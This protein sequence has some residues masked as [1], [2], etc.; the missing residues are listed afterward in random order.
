MKAINLYVI[1]IV[2]VLFMSCNMDGE[3]F[4]LT[5]FSDDVVVETN[6]FKLHGGSAY[7]WD[8]E[9]GK[10]I[11][12][13]KKVM[14]EYD[15]MHVKDIVVKLGYESQTK[16]MSKNPIISIHYKK[17]NTTPE[18]AKSEIMDAL[19]SKYKSNAVVHL[20]YEN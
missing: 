7:Y 9:K 1:G 5:E 8:E 19:L 14:I 20:N 18:K 11:V 3:K 16:H 13:R 15:K 6:M 17:Q 2:A 10:S 4:V 12:S